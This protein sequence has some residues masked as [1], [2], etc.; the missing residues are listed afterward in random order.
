MPF[1][2]LF[3]ANC[4]W[5]FGQLLHLIPVSKKHFSTSEASFDRHFNSCWA[6]LLLE[7]LSW[8][9]SPT[10]KG[11]EPKNALAANAYIH[12]VPTSAPVYFESRMTNQCSVG[13]R[14]SRWRQHRLQLRL[15]PCRHNVF[16]YLY[17]LQDLL[18][19]TARERSKRQM[20][21]LCRLRG[22]TVGAAAAGQQRDKCGDLNKCWVGNWPSA[23]QAS[24]SPGCVNEVSLPGW[25]CK[26]CTF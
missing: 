12:C 3:N 16:V 5:N 9:N 15:V 13:V 18:G 14:G 20:V 10:C 17:I 7:R 23:R 22:K 1:Y 21:W 8:N 11:R 24:S 26:A 19:Q 25:Q 2:R 4:A 6:G